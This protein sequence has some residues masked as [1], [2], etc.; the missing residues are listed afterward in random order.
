MM[1]D[2]ILY[3]LPEQLSDNWKV[4][5]VMKQAQWKSEASLSGYVDCLAILH[6]ENC[7]KA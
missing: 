5:F 2:L 6:C 7:K 1:F 3:L 4:A